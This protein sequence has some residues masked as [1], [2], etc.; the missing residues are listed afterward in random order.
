MKSSPAI[1]TSL[2]SWLPTRGNIIFTLLVASLLFGVQAVG[3]LP[4]RAPAASVTSTAGIPYQGRLAD[5]DGAPLTGTYTMVFRLYAIEAG[6]APLWEEQWTGSNG[7]KV[8]DGLFNVMLGS[9][10]PLPNNVVTGNSSLW[11]GITVNTDNEMTPRVQLGV[12]PY[13]IFAL[14]IANGTVTTVKLVDGAVTNPKLANDA[15]TGEKS[16]PAQSG[17]RI[18][19]MVL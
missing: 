19:R 10:N 18:W 15:V 9:L 14:N 5:A 12:V 17:L 2:R 8:S 4:Y 7:V 1:L 13:T 6:G 11:L 16:W 3:A